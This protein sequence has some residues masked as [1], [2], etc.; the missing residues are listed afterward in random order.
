M[1]I[2]RKLAILVAF[3]VPAI[4]GSGI[5]YAAFGN[6]MSVVIYIVLLLSVAGGFISR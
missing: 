5:V 4:V 3:G 1:S 6:Y 2:I